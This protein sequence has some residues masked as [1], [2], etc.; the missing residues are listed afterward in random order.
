MPW[1]CNW[2]F[3]LSEL[4]LD[5]SPVIFDYIYARWLMVLNRGVNVLCI[6]TILSERW[7]IIYVPNHYLAWRYSHHAERPNQ[8]EAIISSKAHYYFWELLFP[9][10]HC[11]VG[12]P[13]YDIV[14]VSRFLSREV[15]PRLECDAISFPDAFLWLKTHCTIALTFLIL[16]A[17]FLWDALSLNLAN[18]NF[19]NHWIDHTRLLYNYRTN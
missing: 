15:G 3:Y 8:S 5:I 9:W 17:N 7:F 16:Y 13:K 4:N 1:S 11:R 6:Q 19:S 2:S 12:S 14:V 18:V 10:T